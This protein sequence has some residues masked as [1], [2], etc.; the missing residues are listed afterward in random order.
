MESN[1]K[2]DFVE[3]QSFPLKFE[4]ELYLSQVPG[5]EKVVLGYKSQIDATAPVSQIVLF[6]LKTKEQNIFVQGEQMNLNIKVSPDG[7]WLAY[8]TTDF[9]TLQ[10]T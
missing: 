4:K 2:G 7:K 1:E 5:N 8:I 3:K 10:Q 6:D 9:P